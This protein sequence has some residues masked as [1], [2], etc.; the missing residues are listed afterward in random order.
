MDMALRRCRAA[1]AV[2]AAALLGLSACGGGGGGGSASDADTGKFF[3]WAAGSE[4]QWNAFV[5]AAQPQVPNV[6]ISYTGPD[7]TDF[8]TKVQTEYSSGSGPCLVSTQAAR[9]Q[10]LQPVLTPLDDLLKAKGVDV[11]AYDDSMI[12]GMTVGGQLYALPYDSEPFVLY[13]NKA[14]FQKYHL[15]LPGAHF[16]TEQFIQDAKA[17]TRDGNYGFAPSSGFDYFTSFAIGNGA[18]W[19]DDKGNIDL[20]DNAKLESV[21]QQYFD[22]GAKDHSVTQAVTG[23]SPTPEDRFSKGNVGMIVDGTWEYSQ[24]AGYKLP[25]GIAAA[26]SATGNGP[27]MTEGSGWGIAKSCKDKKDALD[28]LLALTSAKT[29]KTVAGA[30]GIMP[31]QKSVQSSWN[32]G[33]QPADIKMIGSILKSTAPQRTTINWNQVQTLFGQYSPLGFSGKES[34]SEVL[35][36]IQQGAS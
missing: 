3:T 8:W 23:D 33:K 6:K 28:V 2:A 13:Y 27:A 18:T 14:L 5:K 31:A 1:L 15:P 10:E 17:L 22:L 11:S 36:K 12:Q 21:L 19:R 24:V 25:F 7:F 9:T 26:P 4:Q 35:S 20:Q 34:A 29:Q 32:A 16:T 30:L